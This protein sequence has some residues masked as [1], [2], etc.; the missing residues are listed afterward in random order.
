MAFKEVKG[1]ESGRGVIHWA[2]RLAAADLLK[3]AGKGPR[4]WAPSAK[5]LRSARSATD[6]SS[7]GE[8]GLPDPG[9]DGGG[10]EVAPGWP[11]VKSGKREKK[12]RW[13]TQNRTA[14]MQTELRTAR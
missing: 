11:L 10:G 7:S 4:I 1:K 14:M 9:E 2:R 6:G 12:R 8:E 3:L 13:M 5:I